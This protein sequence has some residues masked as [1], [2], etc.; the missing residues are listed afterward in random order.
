MS[1]RSVVAGCFASLVLRVARTSGL[2]LDRWI[3]HIWARSLRS[4]CGC[5][6]LLQASGRS[7]HVIAGMIGSV[8][9]VGWDLNRGSESV[10]TR[11]T[12]SAA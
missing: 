9:V 6:L 4:R 1:D 8:D 11:G 10:R 3:V 5:S 12:V 2:P 7:N